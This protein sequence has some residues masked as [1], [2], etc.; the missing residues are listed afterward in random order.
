MSL[1]NFLTVTATALVTALIFSRGDN[2]G[3]HKQKGG[4]ESTMVMIVNQGIR[5]VHFESMLAMT[6]SIKSGGSLMCSKGFSMPLR[7]S[8]P[9]FLL[10]GHL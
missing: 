2:Y 4:S 3:G 8:I 10:P 9:W 1:S 5:L 6:E 7:F